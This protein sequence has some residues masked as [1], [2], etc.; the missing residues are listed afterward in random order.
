M[1]KTQLKN[2]FINGL[3]ILILLVVIQIA[4]DFWLNSFLL[5][6]PPIGLAFYLIIMY[7]IRPLIVGALNVA[8]LHRLYGSQGWTIGFWLNGIFLMLAFSTINLLV[9]AI[10]GIDLSPIV[11]AVEIPLL[12]IPFGFIAKYSNI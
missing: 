5:Y 10:G 8:L 7:L 3:A 9:T 2:L 6:Q 11:M 1:L 12:A 4:L